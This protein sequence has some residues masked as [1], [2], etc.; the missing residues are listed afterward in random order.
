MRDKDVSFVEDI[1]NFR[2]CVKEIITRNPGI[3]LLLI[4]KSFLIVTEQMALSAT[5]E[6]K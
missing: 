2:R 6:E 1:L 5:A 4:R 3:M